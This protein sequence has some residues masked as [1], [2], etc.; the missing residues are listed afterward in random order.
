MLERSSSSSSENDVSENNVEFEDPGPSTSI[1]TL[2]LQKRGRQPIMSV[3]LAAMIDQNLLSDRTAMMIVFESIGALA[4]DPE[5]VAISRSAIRRQRRKDRAVV[6]ASI[7]L[8][9]RPNSPDTPLGWQI[10]A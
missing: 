4:Q 8:A 5:T 6:A 3:P 1:A 9:F 7:V 10:Y 2:S